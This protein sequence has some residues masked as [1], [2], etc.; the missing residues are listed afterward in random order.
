MHVGLQS[1]MTRLFETYYIIRCRQQIKNTLRRCVICKKAHSRH[2]DE[3]PVD[4]PNDRVL[5][6]MPFELIG[7]DFAG[8]FKV[9]ES[10]N[11]KVPVSGNQVTEIEYDGVS[12]AHIALFT[13]LSRSEELVESYIAT[14]LQLIALAH[15]LPYKTTLNWPSSSRSAVSAGSSQPLSHPGGKYSGNA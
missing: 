5:K 8:P 11:I 12:D 6:A 13:E 9:R 15:G 3:V 1:K 2:F 14:T 7:V 10:R 4:L